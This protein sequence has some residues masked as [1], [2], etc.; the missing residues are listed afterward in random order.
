M[1]HAEVLIWNYIR[2]KQVHNIRFRRQFS[3]DKFVVDFYSPK[4]K[5]AIEIDG[6]THLTDEEKEY[7]AWRQNKLEEYGV[8]F[9]RFTNEEV[10]GN[11]NEVL[12]VISFE[13]EAILKSLK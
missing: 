6:L 13:V 7:D 8:K 4:I 12:K 9:L 5:L 1:T 11:I 10:F 2:R 3:I